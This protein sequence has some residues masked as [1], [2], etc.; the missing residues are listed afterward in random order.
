MRILQ[1]CNR[2]PWPLT[3]GGNIAT[4]NLSHALESKGHSV[5]LACLNTQKHFQNHN[6]LKGKASDYFCVDIDTSV[7]W[8]AA[9]VNLFSSVPYI[10]ERFVSDAFR[11]ALRIHL[12]SNRYDV[13][14]IEGLYMAAYIT[15][16]RAC[17][18]T[19]VVFRAHNVEFIIWQ[20][21]AATSVIGLK[22]MYLTLMA[23]SLQRY[24]K[25][26]WNQADAVMFFTPQDQQWALEAGLQV[27][28]EVIPAG[29]N[30][31]D[32]SSPAEDNSIPVIGF[33]GSMDWQPNQDAVKWF[34]NEIFPLVRKQLPN[35]EFHFAGRNMPADFLPSLPDEGVHFLGS[36]PDA[37]AFL[38]SLTC[39]VVPL[40]S[41]AGMRLKILEA[42]AAGCP[43]IS[44][45]VGAE[46]I[47]TAHGVHIL[48]AD[49]PTDFGN[50]VLKVLQSEAI[51]NLLRKNAQILMETQYSWNRIADQ[52]LQYYSQC[53]RN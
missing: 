8:K 7:N 29:V 20:R 22:R 33:L 25:A 11:N 44:T 32:E 47:H 39:M 46:G 34:L 49:T 21:L 13:I 6:I 51:R 28:S 27:K 38:Q 15:D 1:L 43:V 2:I 53:V 37:F 4:W 23:K 14:Q 35:A 36:I 48:F 40:R 24:E 12:K 10:A 30:M 5:T 3:D 52:T 18:N 41:G 19:T 17:T 9:A 42:M 50:E 26:M 45:S 16:I 31:P